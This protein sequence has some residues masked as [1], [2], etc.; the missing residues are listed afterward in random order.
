MEWNRFST[1]ATLLKLTTSD[2]DLD[3]FVLDLFQHRAEIVGNGLSSLVEVLEKFSNVEATDVRDRIFSLL[4]LAA[5]CQ[6]KERDLVD[7][8]INCAPLYFA[9]LA[10]CKPTN[11]MRMAVA[12]Q[13]ALLV[14]RARLSKFWHSVT[15]ESPQNTTSAMKILA[16]EY[17]LKVQAYSELAISRLDFDCF[18]NL[19]NAMDTKVPSKTTVFIAKSY[20]ATIDTGAA[21]LRNSKVFPI[22]KTNFSIRV[23]PTLLGSSFAGVYEKEGKGE[24]H[25]DNCWALQ[26]SPLPLNEIPK[27]MKP[28]HVELDSK[29][30]IATLFVELTTD[31]ERIWQTLDGYF[32]EV[33]RQY[34]NHYGQEL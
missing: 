3:N 8:S 24:E 4:S 1:S 10:Y 6:G 27:Y 21:K 34:R 29:S 25:D 17:V 33:C 16:F 18:F 22:A 13:K 28:P 12:L 9:F 7:Y 14:G 31:N 32:E 20:F 19:P 26:I 5:D 15:P 23:Q 2:K 30:Q 11:V